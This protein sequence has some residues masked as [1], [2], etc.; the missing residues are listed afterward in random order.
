MSQI[1]LVRHGETLWNS[2]GKIQGHLD[3]PLT[4]T[5]LAQAESLAVYFK[6]QKQNFAALYTSDLG[7]AYETARCI[8]EKNGLPVF[9]DPRLRE[10]NFGIFQG[11]LKKT[12]AIQFPEASRY[13]HAHDP[14]YVIPEGESLKQLSERCV[15]CF[16]ELAQKHVGERILVVAHSGVFVSLFK[17]TLG[18]PLD[19]PRRFLSL[20]TSINI[21][22]YQDGI[23]MLEV[24]GDLSHLRCVQSIDDDSAE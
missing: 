21:F 14:D 6:S 4:E 10:R 9:A 1:F 7:R 12:L 17:H 3:S 2:E 13:F 11:A 16:E 5:G 19:A 20:N 22:S 15:K 8:S 18:I 24:W 23:W